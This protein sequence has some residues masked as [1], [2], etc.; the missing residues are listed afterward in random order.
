MRAAVQYAPRDVRVEDVPDPRPAPDEIKV[1]VAYCGVCGTDIEIYEGRF[2]LMK[3]DEWPKGP[4]IEGH[5]A[6]GTIVEMGSDVQQGYEVGQRVAMNFR[7]YC[8]ACYYCR[9]MKEHFCQHTAGATG[10]FAEYAIYK[11]GAV[12]ALPDDVSLERGA[13]LEPLTVALHVTDMADIRPGST[14]AVSG[15]GTIGLLALQLA[16]RSGAARVLVSEPMAEKRQLALDMGADVAVDPLSEDVLE[17]G[18]AL[19]EGR[20]FDSV[21]EISGNLQAVQNT[22]KWADKCATIVWS[23]VYPDEVDIPVNPF[24]LYANEL[25]IRGTIVSPYV[26]P[27]AVKLLSKLDLDPLISAVF[28]LDEIEQALQAH[29][30]GVSIKTLIKP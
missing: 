22:I 4:K 12:Y 30:K 13:L 23:G 28:P 5:E 26:F 29:K 8:G 20:G 10:A 2:G 7:A 19:T 17:A 9:D 25:T 15:A 6:S 11:E 16:L 14:V 21:I 1:K 24:Y 27:R 3:T 18:R